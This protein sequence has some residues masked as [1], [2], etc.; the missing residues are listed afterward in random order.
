MTEQDALDILTPTSFIGSTEQPKSRIGRADGQGLGET[1]RRYQPVAV[2]QQAGAPAQDAPSPDNDGRV[3]GLGPTP[4]QY[5]TARPTTD[6]PV[7][8][9]W[10]AF[11]QSAAHADLMPQSQ[12]LQ[13]EGGREPEIERRFEIKSKKNDHG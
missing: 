5:A 12:V 3:P 13:L 4:S 7:E 6:G 2:S 1:N 11:L 10:G 9:T 8:S